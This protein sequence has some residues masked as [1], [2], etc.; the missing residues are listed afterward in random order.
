VTSLGLPPIDQIGFV[1]HS[2][3]AAGELY[4][5]LYGPFRSYRF[6]I[7]GTTYGGRTVDVDVDVLIGRSGDVAV[8]LIECTNGVG[9][10]A[11]FLAA[12]HEGLHHLRHTIDDWD[13]WSDRMRAHGYECTWVTAAGLDHRYGYFERPGDPLRIELFWNQG[14]P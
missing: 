11:D 1:V 14:S 13:A 9:P 3:Q 2:V 8:E 4:A 7:V 6:P 5:P 12:G 10:H